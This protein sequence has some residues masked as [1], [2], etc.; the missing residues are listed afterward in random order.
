MKNNVKCGQ[1]VF[2]FSILS[3]TMDFARR[4]ALMNYPEGTAVI[5]EEQTAGRGTKGRSWHS[6]R[7]LGLYVSFIFRPQT[8]LLNL[9]PLSAGLA[10]AEAVQKLS[11]VE[12]RLKWPNDLVADGKKLGG[13]L[14]EGVKKGH[15]PGW[16][17]VGLGVN[18]NHQAEDFPHEIRGLATSLF[19]LTGKRWSPEEL[20][21]RLG[22]EL[23]FWYN[24]L[25][26][27]QNSLLLENYKSRLS[28]KPGQSLVLKTQEGEIS[29]QF[30]GI[31]ERGGLRLRFGSN[32]KTF[33]SSEIIKV[34]T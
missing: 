27:G 26:E 13:I 5:A 2:R 12:V 23:Q 25:K 33:Y 24:N 17:I 31:E 7:G 22:L 8:S 11:G 4:L 18:L 16:T 15:Q 10:A 21:E 3:S 20:F 28:F 1:V 9:I 29:G 19:L 14:C 30:L 32:E 6:A 34:L